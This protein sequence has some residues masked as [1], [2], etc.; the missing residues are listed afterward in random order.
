VSG[1]GSAR[2]GQREWTPEDRGTTVAD[3]VSTMVITEYRRIP[4]MCSQS[5][6]RQTSVPSAGG[7]KPVAWQTQQLRNERT[8]WQAT[9]Q[10]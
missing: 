10:G 4:R 8:T 1:L 3:G 5:E 2:M 9:P 6:T 7:E